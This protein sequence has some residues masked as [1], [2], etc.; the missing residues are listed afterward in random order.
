MLNRLRRIPRWV[1]ISCAVLVIVYAVLFVRY[2]VGVP[3]VSGKVSLAWALTASEV[4][5][6]ERAWPILK[7]LE[8]PGE[9][10]PVRDD[11]LW[12]VWPAVAPGDDKW[13]QAVEFVDSRAAAT[14]SVLL[15]SQKR[16]L[17]FHANEWH[18]TSPLNI[19]D[20]N[21]KRVKQD[22]Q[23]PYVLLI[24]V[25]LPQYNVIR[26]AAKLLQVGARVSMSRGQVADAVRNVDAVIA[27]SKMCRETD[28]LVGEI[29]YISVT[30]TARNMVRD[31]LESHPGALDD[32]QLQRLFMTLRDLPAPDLAPGTTLENEIVEDCL[33]R[34][35]TDD[36]SGS[37]RSI[38]NIDS[39]MGRRPTY[40]RFTGPITSFFEPSRAE[41]RSTW[42]RY[43]NA[44][45]VD[46]RTPA[47]Q[48]SELS[49]MKALD[50]IPDR[51]LYRTIRVL[52]NR[53]DRTRS[54]LAMLEIDQGGILAAIALERWRLAHQRYPDS[55]EQLVPS[56]LA[57]VPVDACTGNP[58]VY[59]V[60]DGK[61]LLYSV[62]NDAND[63]LGKVDDPSKRTTKQRENTPPLYG[64][65]PANLRP[66][67]PDADHVLF[68]PS[69]LTKSN[70]TPKQ[71]HS[72][73]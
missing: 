16:A 68:D 65:C 53:E 31:M 39:A 58:L 69:G 41:L 19:V 56:L 24:N 8:A 7:A 38:F 73:P 9:L 43:C 34:L 55:L 70:A 13:L 67:A 63:D 37:G 22:V 40:D 32:G 15:A 33:Q 50:S 49:S 14:E 72:E 27:L 1:W 11:P 48:L 4:P 18:P 29:V 23:A 21:G 25:P 64:W 10:D 46:Q 62:G 12:E 52:I 3:T 44:V 28:D 17:A 2:N 26:R 36:G 66:S 71:L 47:W 6:D 45:A 5:V 61:P 30:A 35:Y 60:T 54:M 59:R 42:Q 57:A 51:G 20:E